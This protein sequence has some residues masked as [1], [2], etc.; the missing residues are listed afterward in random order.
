MGTTNLRC[1]NYTTQADSTLTAEVMTMGACEGATFKNMYTL[2]M[3]ANLSSAL[4]VNTA[5]T[6]TSGLPTLNLTAQA[7]FGRCPNVCPFNNVTNDYD[8]MNNPCQY[9]IELIEIFKPINAT[10]NNPLMVNGPDVLTTCG[11]S[12]RRLTIGETYLVGVGG[13]CN[14]IS[15]WSTLDTYSESEL[16]LLRDL[17]A[18]MG[19]VCAGALGTVPSIVTLVLSLLLIFIV[20]VAV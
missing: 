4:S 8:T 14:P 6:D 20:V 17:S 19:L 13:A 1:V 5:I 12:N 16:D 11:N 10:F 9:T 3:C 2:G 18:D 7:E 15:A